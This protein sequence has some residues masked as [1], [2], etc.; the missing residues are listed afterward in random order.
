MNSRFLFNNFFS[1][2]FKRQLEF[3]FDKI[4]MKAVALSRRQRSNLFKI[5]LNRLLP[6]SQAFGRPYMAHISPSGLC[7]LSCLNCPTKDMR[8]RGRK[9]MP[10]DTFRK[11]IDEAGDTL[12]YVILWSWGEPLLNP[13]FPRMVEYAA[14]RNILTVSSTNLNRL[15]VDQ[16]RD[17][18]SSGLDKLIIAVDGTTQESYEKYRKGGDLRRI[19]ENIKLLVAEKKR[20]GAKKPFLNLRMVVSRENEHEIEDFRRMGRELKVDMISFKAFS[21]RQAGYENPEMD[22]CFAPEMEKYRWY[23]YRKNFRADRRMGKYWCRFPWTKPTLF[24][25]GTII[26][27]EYDFHYEYPLGNINQ[28]SFDDIWFGDKAKKFRRI[29]QKNRDAFAFCQDCVYDY[30]LIDGCILERELLHHEE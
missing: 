19:V 18:V 24:A 20:V 15:S 29:F 27:C 10:F 1:L 30:T 17:L 26:T 14:R 21:T 4:P 2:V 13:D 22:R 9:F 25:D 11:F 5:A 3:E 6:I 16:A 12:L 8:T 23:Q 28:Q 7:D